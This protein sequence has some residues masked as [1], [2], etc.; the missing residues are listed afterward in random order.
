MRGG[1]V[2]HFLPGCFDHIL[3]VKHNMYDGDVIAG[4]INHK[5]IRK[6]GVAQRS[7]LVRDM[8]VSILYFSKKK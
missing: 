6:F 5:K 3:C 1:I 4:K 7:L 8:A 2:L